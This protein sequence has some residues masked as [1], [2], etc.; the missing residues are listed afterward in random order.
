[1]SPYQA[2]KC[3]CEWVD[4]GPSEKKTTLGWEIDTT[5]QHLI[6]SADH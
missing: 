5:A 4:K 3:V 2:R 6:T 1:M